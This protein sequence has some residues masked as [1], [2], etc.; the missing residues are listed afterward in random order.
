MK[1]TA[2]FHQDNH[3]EHQQEGFNRKKQL[4]QHLRNER[5]PTSL[6]PVHPV[7]AFPAGTAQTL[8]PLTPYYYNLAKSKIVATAREYEMAMLM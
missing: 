4:H 6:A 5:T 8:K 7:D 3:R 1:A 2:T